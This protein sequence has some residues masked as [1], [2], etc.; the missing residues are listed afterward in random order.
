MA[1]KIKLNWKKIGYVASFLPFAAI[2][3]LFMYVLYESNQ[4]FFYQIL[5][6]KM[7][8]SS[9][10]LS[11]SSDVLFYVLAAGSA[12]LAVLA[13]A[14]RREKRFNM[15]ALIASIAVC[16]AG[17]VAFMV[18]CHLVGVFPIA[19]ENANLYLAYFLF[20]VLANA[21]ALFSSIR[22]LI[23]IKRAPVT[24]AKSAEKSQE[25]NG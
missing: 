6:E 18:L 25:N 5:P 14:K 12:I 21:L 17:A 19:F 1:A 16:V 22:N 4:T 3:A 10:A 9:K 11:I 8:I 7:D 20:A 2:S 15:A 13:I 24:F 23:K